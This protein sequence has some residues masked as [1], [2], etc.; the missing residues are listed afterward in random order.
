[1]AMWVCCITVWHC[2]AIMIFVGYDVFRLLFY[3]LRSLPVMMFV[4]NFD[5]WRLWRLSLIMFVAIRMFVGYDIP[6]LAMFVAYNVCCIVTFVAFWC[7]FSQ[8]WHLLVITFMTF[9]TNY[10]VSQL[11]CLLPY[12]VC[13]LWRLSIIIFVTYEVFRQLWRLSLIRFIRITNCVCCWDSYDYFL[14]VYLH[15]APVLLPF[16]AVCLGGEQRQFSQ[17]TRSKI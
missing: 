1:M 3:Q 17:I 14:D 4:A 15:A 5:V 16:L 11:W 2:L 7:F 13:R 8:L 12:Y 10:D 6:R 9:V